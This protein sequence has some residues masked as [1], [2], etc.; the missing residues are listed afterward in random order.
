MYHDD[1]RTINKHVEAEGRTSA[2]IPYKGAAG[3][4]KS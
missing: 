4:S 2:A 3:S 1:G